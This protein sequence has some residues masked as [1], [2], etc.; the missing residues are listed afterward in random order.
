[1][2]PRSSTDNV[3]KICTCVKWKTCSHPWYLDY[4][5]EGVR[6]RD[7]LDKLIGRHAKDFNA[8]KDEAR[9]AIIAK[10]EG[11]D[12]RGLVPADDPTLEQM[13]TQYVTERP[14]RD[15]WQVPKLL[16][17]PVP[18]PDGRPR[19]GDWRLSAITTETLKQFRQLRPHVAGNRDLN[20]LRAAFNWAVLGGLMPRSPFRIGDVP[21]IRLGRELART[22]RLH[23]GEADGLLAATSGLWRDLITA[24]LETGMRKGEL[25][26]LQWKQVRFAPRAEIFLPADKTKTKRDRRVPI[27]TVCRRVLESRQRDPAGDVLGP[28]A[29]VFGNEI[30]KPVT[31]SN[32]RP[33]ER[34]VLIANGKTPRTVPRYA[35]EGAARRRIGSGPLTRE[36][37]AALRTI[38]L[39]FHD[40]RREAGSR[41][42]DAGIP[43]ATIQR[44]LGHTNIAQTSTYLG[45]SLGG[46][47]QDMEAYE[48][49]MGRL[50]RLTQ[51][52]IPA[53][54]T[55]PNQ[56]TTDTTPRK[57]PNK[58][59][60]LP[61]RAETVH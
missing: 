5:R 1:M 52:D 34:A 21:A 46:D 55:R 8:A 33:W 38:N 58:N 15:R 16:S 61:S 19:F 48:R 47:E 30:G 3:R 45:A 14:R 32:D 44:W 56:T 42:M 35:G 49:A 13:L 36:S 59:R 27:S 53:S 29:Y 22:R 7:N 25:L 11:R 4:Q 39:H 2:P 9:R 31:L 12:P 6:Y 10:Q 23:P 54:Q 43:L 18:S 57:N 37:R 24:A 40:L 20:L 26:S 41:W 60:T 50:T 28:E 17:V 51:I